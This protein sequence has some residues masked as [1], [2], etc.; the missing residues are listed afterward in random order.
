MPDLNVLLFLTLA[1]VGFITAF[2][3][4]D[5][6]YFTD[7]QDPDVKNRGFHAYSVHSQSVY[8]ADVDQTGR[9][10]FAAVFIDIPDLQGQQGN[11]RIGLELD[12]I[13]GIHASVSDES[14]ASCDRCA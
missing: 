11:G 8:S 14:K 9:I 10:G 12:F 1:L 5:G 7:D 2:L 13:A 6:E 3:Y 4:Q